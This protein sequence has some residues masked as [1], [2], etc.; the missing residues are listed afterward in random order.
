MRKQLKVDC[1]KCALFLLAWFQLHCHQGNEHAH[2]TACWNYIFIRVSAAN[3]HGQKV[4]RTRLPKLF[5]PKFKGDVTK[6][7]TFWDLTSTK[8]GHP[9]SIFGKYLFGRRFEI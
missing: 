3:S 1:F 2:A 6:W 4:V 8:Q 9:T 5:L 7:N